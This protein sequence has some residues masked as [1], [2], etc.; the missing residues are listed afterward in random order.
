MLR[1]MRTAV[2][3]AL[4]TAVPAIADITP[5]SLYERVVRDYPYV[6]KSLSMVGAGGGTDNLFTVTGPVEIK[7]LGFWVT[8]ATD[9]TIVT[10]VG[11]Q[12]WDGTDI[13]ALDDGSLAI[14]TCVLGTLVAKAAAVGSGLVKVDPVASLFGEA[15]IGATPWHGFNAAKQVGQTTY[16]RMGW[17]GNGATDLEIL[18]FVYYMSLGGQ[19]VPV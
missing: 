13:R 8:T 6:E 3:Q 2:A 17:T 12:L 5:G 10:G 19:V 1:Q 18:A 15:V 14:S 11:F 7:R 16:L 4:N 9:T